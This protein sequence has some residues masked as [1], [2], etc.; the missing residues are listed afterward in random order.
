MLRLQPLPGRDIAMGAK[1]GCYAGAGCAVLKHAKTLRHTHVR[2][3]NDNRRIAERTA[4]MIFRYA[5][6]DNVLTYA[7][8]GWNIAALEGSPHGE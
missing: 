6:H 2:R 3:S 7:L 4:L 5:P 1:R 8:L